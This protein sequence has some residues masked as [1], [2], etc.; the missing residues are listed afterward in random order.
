[1]KVRLQPF[2]PGLLLALCGCLDGPS[3]LTF[4]KLVDRPEIWPLEVTLTEP[5][6]ADY[7]G[8]EETLP[9]GSTVG[10]SE[11]YTDTLV[12]WNPERGRAFNIP[13]EKTDIVDRARDIWRDGIPER[14]RVSR[15]LGPHL[16][17]VATD[18]TLSS[19][20]PDTL[21]GTDLVVFYYAD[22]YNEACVYLAEPLNTRYRKLRDTHPYFEMVFISRDPIEARFL[23]LLKIA[24][25]A[26]PILDHEHRRRQPTAL[27]HDAGR[28]PS[29]IAVDRHGRTL[30]ASH[31]WNGSDQT[32]A[33]Y[34]KG[35][36]ELLESRAVQ[37]D[38]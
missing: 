18:G 19:I 35:L 36:E 15:D 11:V 20:P 30:L 33:A 4:E 34:F 6:L 21:D 16:R 9:A 5:H 25:P 13:A 1:M 7:R 24:P 14:G 3:R 32:P 17:K 10:V 23:R 38:P 37:E 22:T 8:E 27:Q 28:P 12:C 29:F 26:F 2:A 31:P